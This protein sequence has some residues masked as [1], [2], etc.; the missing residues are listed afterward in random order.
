M[1]H[2]SPLPPRLSAAWRKLAVSSLAAGLALAL[3]GCA[4]V[5]PPNQAMNQAQAQ[6][7]AAR[8]AGAA[9]YD[10]VDLGFAQDKLQQAQ[11]AM[12]AR[13]YE[14]AAD[15]AAESQVD[16]ELARVKANLGAARSQIQVKLDENT[17]LREQGAA[18]AAAAAAKFAQPLATPAAAGSSSAPASAAELP[19]AAPL[20]DMPAPSSSVL[21]APMPIQHPPAGGQDPNATQG[22]QP[23]GG[24]P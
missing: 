10:P 5:P 4:T 20:E 21:S 22:F 11:G 9:D 8:D 7:Q 1:V 17:R 2:T 14:L 18:A 24:Q 12:A 19:P 23:A 13:K 3:A 16:A 15:L 6:L